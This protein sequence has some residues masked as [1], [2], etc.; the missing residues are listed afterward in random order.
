MKTAVTR[1]SVGRPFAIAIF[2]MALLPAAG[3]AA[4]PGAGPLAVLTPADVFRLKRVGD[5][6]I[7]P[8]GR[9]VAYLASDTDIMIDGRRSSIRIIDVATGRERVLAEDASSPRWSPDG[10]SIAYLGRRPGG[11]FRLI[12]AEP[13]RDAR[14][15][16]AELPD[17]PSAIVWSPD[18]ST[19]AFT[20]FVAADVRA[21][22]V[23]VRQP[24]GAKWAPPPRVITTARYQSDEGGLL[25]PGRDRLFTVPISGGTPAQHT[26][27]DVDVVGDPAWT[28]DGAAI[29]IA[30]RH[31]GER[32][33]GD[34]A[35]RLYR[36]PLSGGAEKALSPAGLVALAQAVSPDGRSIAF[37][38]FA[39]DGRDYSPLGLYVMGI[40]GTGLHRLDGKLDRDVYEPSWSPDGRSIYVLSNDRGIDTVLRFGLDGKVALV[41]SGTFDGYTV[42]CDGAIAYAMGRTDRPADVAVKEPGGPPRLLTARNDTVLATKTLATVRPLEVRSSLDR[43]AVGAWLTLPPGHREGQRHPMILSIHG[44]PYG[45][46]SP[47][48]STTDQLYAAAGYAVLHANYRGSVSY[49][50]AF[51]DRIARDFPG[52][53][54]T[55][56]IS[57]VDAAVAGGFAEPARLFVTGGSAGGLLT[58]WIVGSTDRFRAAMAEKPVINSMSQALTTDQYGNAGVEFGSKPWDV[59]AKVWAAS[60]LSLVGRVKTPTLIVVGE[61]D[62]RTPVSESLQFYNALIIRGIPSELV[63]M[64][65]ASHSTL[66]SKP[67]QLVS[68]IDLTLEWFARYGGLGSATSEV[69]P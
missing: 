67:S 3:T 17:V 42:S 52:P 16:V 56:L 49:G 35:V 9:S 48:W 68:A 5:V 53:A 69:R 1:R 15:T 39:N 18:G 64:P 30:E 57:A 65:G 29:V 47:I 58:A 66:G 13:A 34:G 32:E 26:S 20:M 45:Y 54:Y 37:S 41:A 12:V 55:D 36:V 11:K 62:R 2:V 8:D 10:R 46:D 43:H 50:F 21:R 60:P 25:R 51:A 33:I 23:S 28:A 14:R 44:G 27:G 40:D 61:E 31:R 38:A 7:S 59:S 4:P 24:Q 19:L 6:R 22:V 63:I